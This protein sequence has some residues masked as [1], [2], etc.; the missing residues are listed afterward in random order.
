[1]FFTTF[2]YPES[3]GLFSGA[4]IEENGDV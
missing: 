4:R 2:S 3:L 1:V